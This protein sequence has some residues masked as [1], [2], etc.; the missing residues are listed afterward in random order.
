MQEN[1]MG[2][3]GYHGLGCGL[4]GLVVDRLWTTS[5]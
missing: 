3:L 1:R 5:Q 4:G 2:C